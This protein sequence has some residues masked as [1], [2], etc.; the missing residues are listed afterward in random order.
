MSRGFSH[1][2]T[3]AKLKVRSLFAELIKKAVT[4]N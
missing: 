3:Q 4:T 1:T 2:H